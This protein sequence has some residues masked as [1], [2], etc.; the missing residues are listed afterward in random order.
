MHTII[1]DKG[2]HTIIPNK[3]NIIYHSFQ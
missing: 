2:M 3:N 1:F